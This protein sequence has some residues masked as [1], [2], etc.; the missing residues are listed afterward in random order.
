MAHAEPPIVIGVGASAGGVQALTDL[1]AALPADLRAAVLVVLHISPDGS[2]ALAD[3]LDRAGPLR[4][5]NAAD[6][7]PIEAGRIYVACPDRH[8]LVDGDR[9]RLGNGP[10]ENGHRP[11]VDPLFRTLAG[12]F[13]TRAAG[14]VLSGSRDDGTVGLACIKGAGGAALA[15]DPAEATYPGMPESAIEHVDLD[16]VATIADLATR[17]TEM[18]EHAPIPPKPPARSSAA[19]SLAGDPSTPPPDSEETMYTCPECGG[20]LHRT[21]TGEVTHFVCRVGHAYSPGSLVQEHERAVE[22]AMWAASRMLEDRATLLREMAERARRGDHERL[23]A[24]YETRAREAE[25]HADVIRG[26]IE[27]SLREDAA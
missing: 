11:A 17:I 20:V 1:A 13:G 8:L 5:T 15:Q 21:A 9:L 24:R 23:I 22:A 4:A 3:I 14:I 2:S 18:S 26:I 12:A 10:R 25:G 19:E 27:A 16:A 6:G 7:D